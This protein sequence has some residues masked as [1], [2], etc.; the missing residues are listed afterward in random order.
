MARYEVGGKT[1]LLV[2][3]HSCW[4]QPIHCWW[5]P[6]RCWWHGIKLVATHSCWW[7]VAL[8][9]S[10]VPSGSFALPPG[11]CVQADWTTAKAKAKVKT[12]MKGTATWWCVLF[13]LIV[14]LPPPVQKKSRTKKK[15]KITAQSIPMWSP[16]IVLTLPSTV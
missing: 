16:T 1:F 4:W 3:T 8:P 12:K 5:Q 9:V 15:K 13:T 6:T 2:A 11:Q 10:I 14:T 7:Q